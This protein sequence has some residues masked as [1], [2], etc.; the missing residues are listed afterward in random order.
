[1]DKKR[2]NYSL[3]KSGYVSLKIYDILGKEVATLVNEFKTSGNYTINFSASDHTSGVY[4]YKLESNDF[5]EVKKMLLI[6]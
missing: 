1:M 3:P 2:I 4:F 5:I 6:K